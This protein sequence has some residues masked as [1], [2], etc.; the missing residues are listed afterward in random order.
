MATSPSDRNN[1]DVIAWLDRLEA[2]VQRA[3]ES[4]GSKAFKFES[5]AGNDNGDGEDSDGE[6][7]GAGF[8]DGTERGSVQQF[9]TDDQLKDADDKLQALPDATVPLGLLAS[10]SLSNTK[11]SRKKSPTEKGNAESSDED[12]VVCLFSLYSGIYRLTIS[13]MAGRGKRDILHARYI[14]P[15]R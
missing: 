15:H 12:N 11:K 6:P 5:R 13:S 10:L 9:D 4:G 7:E 1:R 3:G 8:N 2:S 14:P